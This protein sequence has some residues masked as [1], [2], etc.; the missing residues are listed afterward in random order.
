MKKVKNIYLLVAACPALLLVLLALAGITG[1]S[2][3]SQQVVAPIVATEEKAEE[4]ATVASQLGAPWDIVILTDAVQASDAGASGIE[5]TNPIYTT[6]QFLILEKTTE[7]Y[8]VV[9]QRIDEE[10][11]EVVD[12]YD[13]VVKGNERFPARAQII[14]F[15]GLTEADL[16]TM[17]PDRLSALAADYG[18]TKSNEEWKYSVTFSVNGD[19]EGVLRQYVGLKDEDIER[20]MELYRESY[21]ALMNLSEEAR[22]RIQAIQA[23]YGLY[24]YADGEYV[25]CEGLTFNEGGREVIYFNQLDSRWAALPYGRLSTIGRAGCGPTAMSIVISTLAGQTVDPPYM[26]NWSVANGQLCDGSGSYRTLIPRAAEAFGLTVSDAQV[27]EG[28]R[29]VN[30]LSDGALVVAIMGPGDFTRSGHFIVLRAVREDGKILIA[31]PASTTRT[32][33]AWDLSLILSQVSRT[34]QGTGPLWI[35]REAG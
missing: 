14:E 33:Q 27:T 13:W 26:C 3:V 17:T 5:N 30:A 19:F 11:E 18:A 4:Y 2:S 24:Q 12:I 15:F 28:Q 25:S 10:T 6:L 21:M 31:D 32:G 20:I 7:H 16:E 34:V 23:R 35:I 9:G 22:T 8:E 29:I 1:G